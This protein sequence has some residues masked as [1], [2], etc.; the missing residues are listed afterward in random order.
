VVEDNGIGFNP[1]E[2]RGPSRQGGL[3]LYGMRER[4][5][6]LRGSLTIDTA[7]GRGTRIS[8]LA[9]AHRVEPA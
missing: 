1:E 6:L 3:G 4:A 9:P 8:L 5:A 2:L 7:P